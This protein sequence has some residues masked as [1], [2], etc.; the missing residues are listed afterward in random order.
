MALPAHRL[1]MALPLHRL[2]MATMCRPRLCLQAAASLQA[3]QDL[4][5]ALHRSSQL[6]L[7]R[8]QAGEDLRD[9][10]RQILGSDCDETMLNCCCYCC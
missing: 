1:G 7:C 6:L 9:R 3:G 10:V 8:H 2:A 5:H 4:A